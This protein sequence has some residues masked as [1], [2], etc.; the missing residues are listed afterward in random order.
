MH[1]RLQARRQ[2]VALAKMQHNLIAA[3][4]RLIHSL[5]CLSQL[6]DRYSNLGVIARGLRS[7][8]TLLDI[9]GPD[10]AAAMQHIKQHMA[11]FT[12]DLLAFDPA[13]DLSPAA[14]K[15]MS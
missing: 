4:D 5:D 6:T 2:L 9:E 8:L 12:A 15:I 3:L 14:T 11:E 13:T 10:V 1:P 7:K